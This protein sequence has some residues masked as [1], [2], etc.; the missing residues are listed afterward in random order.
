M[1]KPF[2]KERSEILFWSEIIQNRYLTA[3]E[4]FKRVIE[5]CDGKIEKVLK[6]ILRIEMNWM[7]DMSEKIAIQK[8]C[9]EINKI[10]RCVISWKI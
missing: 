8:E 10:V 1:R 7:Y 2:E 4:D 6:N 9:E 5:F 3:T